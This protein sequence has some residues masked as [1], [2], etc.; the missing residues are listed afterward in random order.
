MADGFIR[1]RMSLPRGVKEGE[2]HRC[3]EEVRKR[4]GSVQHRI[5]HR[6]RGVEEGREKGE[7]R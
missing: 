6:E 5:K 1:G 4:K 2:T 3:G 7:G